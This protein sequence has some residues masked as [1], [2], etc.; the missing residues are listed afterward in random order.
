VVVVVVVVEYHGFS[1]QADGPETEG[2]W[3]SWLTRLSA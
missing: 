1:D 3:Q 2:A